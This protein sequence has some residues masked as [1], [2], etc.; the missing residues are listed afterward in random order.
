MLK[1]NIS[2]CTSVGICE[3]A[4]VYMYNMYYIPD[5]FYVDWPGSYVG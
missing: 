4:Q 3:H 1:I 2:A 5:L